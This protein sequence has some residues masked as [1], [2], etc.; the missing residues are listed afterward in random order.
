MANPNDPCS[1]TCIEC[2]KPNT[3]AARHTPGATTG[4]WAVANNTTINPCSSRQCAECGLENAYPQNPHVRRTD[5]PCSREC[6]K[7]CNETTWFAHEFDSCGDN[8]C[9]HCGGGWPAERA[10]TFTAQSPTKCIGCGYNNPDICLKHEYDNNCDTKCNLCQTPRY[11]GRDDYSTIPE[12][13]H[14]LESG[15]D[16]EC[17]DCKATVAAAHNYKKDCSEICS[18]CGQKRTTLTAHTY[19]HDCDGEC[20]E[21]GETREITHFFDY[22]CDP[23]CGNVK[24]ENPTRDVRA[25]HLYD[26][27]CDTSCGNVGCIMPDRKVPH[28]YTSDC[29]AVCDTEGCGFERTPPVVN[30][31][32]TNDCDTVCDV[33]KCGF[34]RTPNPHKYDNDCDVD[35]NVCKTARE[36]AGHGYDNDC[37]AD[38]NT[39]GVTREVGAHKY[40]NACDGDCN[41]CGATR[42]TQHSFSVWMT[43]TE[44]TKKED[45]VSTRYCTVCN[46]DETQA[47]PA[48]GGMSTG[49]VVAIVVGSVSV[50]GGGG[51]CLYWFVLKKKFLG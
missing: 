29:D 28:V 20:N 31:Q 37:D 11:G 51:F 14:I 2:E 30:H 18:D 10:H 47:I 5:K 46:F 9:A 39:C 6:A 48:E 7:K 3:V 12:I 19:D 41:S 35:C 22:A 21:C 23:L 27:V 36:V 32:W 50:A 34:T 45:G 15:C 49:A 33:E 44:P 8:T 25:L 4:A 16:S 38:C 1:S 17:N 42:T 40:D 43:T 24:C 13:W 26:S